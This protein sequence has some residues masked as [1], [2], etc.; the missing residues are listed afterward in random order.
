MERDDKE[1]MLQKYREKLVTLE[2]LLQPASSTAV[3]STAAA[4]SKPAASKAASATSAD[5]AASLDDD[6]KATS[7]SQSSPQPSPPLPTKQNRNNPP[8]ISKETVSLIRDEIKKLEGLEKNSPEF[9]VT[10]SYLDWL[11]ALPWGK[12][13]QDRLE[14]QTARG[15]L[16]EDHYGLQE[17][18]ERILE[19]I[20][21]GKLKGTVA[22]KILCFIGPPGDLLIDYLSSCCNH[23]AP[24]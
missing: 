2:G 22:G 21:V 23:Y 24:L 8:G 13:S 4:T 12:F 18:K 9:N 7:S 19:F 5:S 17:I 3:S 15:I 14:L 6:A 1:D 16:D 10:R 20:A 11:V